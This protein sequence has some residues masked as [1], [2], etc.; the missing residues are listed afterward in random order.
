[1]QDAL[2][3]QAGAV[4]NLDITRTETEALVSSS[5]SAVGALQAVQAGNQL[6]ALQTRQVADLTAVIAAQSRAQSLAGAR[7]S[8]NQEP[9]PAPIKSRHASS[10]AAS[11]AVRRAISLK[12][13]R[14]SIDGRTGSWIR[15][16]SHGLQ[17]SSCSA[18]PC[19][20]AHS[21]WPGRVAPSILPYRRRTTTW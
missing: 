4:G 5:Q 7:P 18:S 11:S 14:C 9:A 2:R 6:V 19:S 15:R 20:R 10:S 8:A 21:N 3:V 13:S 1:Y 17:L 12:P 16:S